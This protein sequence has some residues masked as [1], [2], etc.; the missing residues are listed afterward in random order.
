[1]EVGALRKSTKDALAFG[2][3]RTSRPRNTTN[4][5]RGNQVNPSSGADNELRPYCGQRRG[6]PTPSCTE[7]SSAT[8][9]RDSGDNAAGSR[10][11]ATATARPPSSLLLRRSGEDAGKKRV[12]HNGCE[13]ERTS[14]NSTRQPTFRTHQSGRKMGQ[15]WR[16]SPVAN[17]PDGIHGATKWRAIFVCRTPMMT[18]RRSPIESIYLFCIF[19]Y[20]NILTRIHHG[21]AMSRT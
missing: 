15:G 19:D 21:E 16:C 6:S 7:S 12:D 18:H 8:A 14:K 5:E 17:A 10:F 13:S 20:E 3:H 11:K 1:V 2:R 4:D 9:K